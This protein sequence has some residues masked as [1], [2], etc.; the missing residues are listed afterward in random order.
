[1]KDRKPG[2]PSKAKAKTPKALKKGAVFS[3]SDGVRPQRYNP[4]RATAAY[5]ALGAEA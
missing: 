4:F 2:R 1:M 5:Y 3:A